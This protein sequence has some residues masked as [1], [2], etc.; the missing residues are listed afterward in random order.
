M[1]TAAT[2]STSNP[3]ATLTQADFLQLL[4]TQMTQQDPLNPES[5][6]DFAAQLAQFSSL[7]QASNMAG[8]MANMQATSLIGSTVNVASSTGS[9]QSTGIVSG[10]QMSGG[11]PQIEVNGQLYDL[12]QVLT[13]SPTQ[14]ST[15]T[16]G[17]STT[18][19]SSTGN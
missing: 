18:T 19:G 13:I 4:V 6:T 8:S 10:I 11:T 12:S 17:T 15:G 5:D 7:Q 2:A 1:T 14:A 9:T 3:N 16:T